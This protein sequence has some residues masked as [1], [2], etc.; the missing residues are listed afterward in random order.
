MHL[1]EYKFVFNVVILTP[2]L[3]RYVDKTV[4]HVVFARFEI[5]AWFAT[6]ANTLHLRQNAFMFTYYK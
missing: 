1:Y 4:V 6:R 3:K 2:I 5:N